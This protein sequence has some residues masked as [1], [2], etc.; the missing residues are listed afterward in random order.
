MDYNNNE[1]IEDLT[2]K[3]RNKVDE[4]N[5]LARSIVPTSE[6]L[7]S[8]IVSSTFFVV[9]VF[10]IGLALFSGKAA[11]PILTS[12]LVPAVG[13]CVSV[14]IRLYFHNIETTVKYE[15]LSRKQQEIDDL[16]V[17]IK[18]Q[19][20]IQKI[21]TKQTSKENTNNEKQVIREED[22]IDYYLDSKAEAVDSNK[23]LV[24][25]LD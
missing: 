19:R 9:V 7:F 13:V 8:L 5:I 2:Y 3:L 20:E 6:Y 14:P 4:R 21:I 25:K 10:G 17:E 1:M 22:F 16:V 18:R 15:L 23:K 11:N 12:F 24:K